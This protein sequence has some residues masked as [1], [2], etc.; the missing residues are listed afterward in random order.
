MS[1]NRV[2]SDWSDYVFPSCQRKVLLADIGKRGRSLEYS[3]RCRV[4][5]LGDQPL[6]LWA[7]MF[8]G[9]LAD[10]TAS[11]PDY[12][13][14]GKPRRHRLCNANLLTVTP[15]RDSKPETMASIPAGPSRDRGPFSPRRSIMTER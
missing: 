12:R 13:V 5:K 2:L 15:A 9:Q 3:L 4:G 10:I 11:W 8:G 1:I 14:C 7:C 6:C